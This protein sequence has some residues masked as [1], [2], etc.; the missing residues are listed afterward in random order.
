MYTHTV[1]YCQW[2]DH[3]RLVTRSLSS[4][5]SRSHL[6]YSAPHL[7]L[8]RDPMVAAVWYWDLGIMEGVTIHYVGI[9]LTW[10]IRCVTDVQC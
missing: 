9:Q 4:L 2:S 7:E 10:R 1:H 6:E 8:D 3:W 5:M